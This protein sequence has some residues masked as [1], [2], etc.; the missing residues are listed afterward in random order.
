M[1][2]LETDFIPLV[3][4]NNVGGKDAE[5]LKQYREPSWNN[6]VVRFV[7]STGAD[8]IPRQSGVYS[9]QGISTRMKT[10][11]EKTKKVS[12]KGAGA[13]AGAKKISRIAMSQ[14]C[15]WTGELEIGGIEGVVRTEAGWLEGHEVTLV[16]YDESVIKQDA[17][18]KKAKAASCAN[19][20]YS[21]NALAGYRTAREA[22]QKRQLQG[23][24]FA[25]VPNLTD[26]QKTKLNAFAR[27][28][29]RKA[30]TFLTQDQLKTL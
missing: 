26:Y 13:D 14:Y 1:K 4:R 21:G 20:V 16:D 25:K 10:V 29:P 17:L 12:L 2:S 27:G 19:K 18:V 22:D 7:D 3:V 5:I 15:F 28:N 9:K 30:K 6:P 11:L 23:T 8:I 24:A